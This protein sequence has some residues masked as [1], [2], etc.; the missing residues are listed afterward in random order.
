M[1]VASILKVKGADVVTGTSEETLNQVAERLW[2]KRIGAVVVL[3]RAGRV[4]GIIS[5]RDIVIAIA[6]DG[7]QALAAPV[8]RHMTREVM[9][10]TRQ[11]SVEHCMEVMTS[12]RFRHLPVVE[13]GRL[14]G[15]VSIGDVVKARIAA[16]EHEAEA[17]R[18]YITAS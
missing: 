4:E 16:A 9:T 15:I 6:R 2:Q 14:V 1:T 18:S 5:E 7:S 8:D 13:E 17:M 3:S 12:G 10:C 11:D